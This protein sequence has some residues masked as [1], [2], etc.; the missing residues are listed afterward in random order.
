MRKKSSLQ[1]RWKRVS[2]CAFWTLL[3]SRSLTPLTAWLSHMLMSGGAWLR[4]TK[5]GVEKVRLLDHKQVREDTNG[6]DLPLQSLGVD[7]FPCTLQQPPESMHS[8]VRCQNARET[9]WISKTETRQMYLCRTN[10]ST[11]LSQLRHYWGWMMTKLSRHLFC[12]YA[13]FCPS[14]NNWRRTKVP[15]FLLRVISSCDTTRF[16]H[17]PFTGL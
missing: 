1:T 10:L 7:G 12:C 11:L 2:R 16:G 6:Q 15:H 8:H 17:H 9:M 3:P 4:W 5:T 13:I 14:R